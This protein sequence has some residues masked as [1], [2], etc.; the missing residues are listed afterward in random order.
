MDCCNEKIDKKLL[1]YCFNISEHA[2]FE[3]LKQNKAHILKEFVVF[4]TKHNYC[5][6]KNLNPSK[7]CCLKDFKALEKTKKKDQSSTR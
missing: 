3:A 2:Y 5:H 1:C 4:Q 7:Q 6:C